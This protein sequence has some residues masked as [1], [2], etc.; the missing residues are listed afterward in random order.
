[1]YWPGCTVRLAIVRLPEG[2]YCKDGMPMR[3]LLYYM[4]NLPAVLCHE[5]Q[6]QPGI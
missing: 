3:N 2:T 5:W 1:M 6:M 4:R